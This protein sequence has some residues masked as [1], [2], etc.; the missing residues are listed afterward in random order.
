MQCAERERLLKDSRFVIVERK[1]AMFLM[2]VGHNLCNFLIQDIFQY[3]GETVGHHFH[4][5]LHAFA[6][7]SK[8]MIK[9]PSLE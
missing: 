2:S 3:S 9:P 1:V 4:T 5:V 6:V 8:K 7:F